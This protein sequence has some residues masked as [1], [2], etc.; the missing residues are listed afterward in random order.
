[1]YFRK[2]DTEGNDITTYPCDDG[3]VM[4]HKMIDGVEVSEVAA[5]SFP[6]ESIMDERF[7]LWILFQCFSIGK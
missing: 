4:F 7:Y 5:E 3:D 6:L 2:V 1:M